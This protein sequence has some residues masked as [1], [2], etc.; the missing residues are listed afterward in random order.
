[1]TEENKINREEL[2]YRQSTSAVILDKIGRML[3][4]Q[5]NS[6]KDNEWNIPGGG[7]EEGETPET[8]IIRE[9]NE[10]LGSDKFEIV[11][12]AS[13]TD[14]YEWPNELIN[15]KIAQNKAVFRGQEISQFLVKFLGKDENLKPEAQEIRE[16]KWVFP[17]ELPVYLIFPSQMQRTEI[18]LREFGVEIN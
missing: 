15:E 17:K 11:K 5:K 7:I 14:H 10:E 3:L 9:L 2:T 8:T 16:I 18:L 12:A 6:Y 1:M 13:Q 4:V